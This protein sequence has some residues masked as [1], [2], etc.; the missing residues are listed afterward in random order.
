MHALSYFLPF[1]RTPARTQYKRV[2]MEAVDMK[3]Y[4]HFKVSGAASLDCL[5]NPEAFAGRG[6]EWDNAF[7]RQVRL[8]YS[9]KPKED[10]VHRLALHRRRFQD[11]AKHVIEDEARQERLLLEPYRKQGLEGKEAEAE[12]A[13]SHACDLHAQ[14]ADSVADAALKLARIEGFL[15]GEEEEVM[16]VGGGEAPAVPLGDA[17]VQTCDSSGALRPAGQGRGGHDEV[18]AVREIGG[19]HLMEACLFG[20]HEKVKLLV[21]TQMLD[22]NTLDSATGRT[23]LSLAAAY[24]CSRSVHVLLGAGAR[25][26]LR[27]ADGSILL[28][29]ACKRGHGALIF[30][31][32]QALKSAAPTV[33]QTAG[34]PAEPGPRF[35]D[36]VCMQNQYG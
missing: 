9:T 21:A 25:P 12:E 15:G 35:V 32:S 18:H 26:D 30:Y 23:P 13:S 36:L 34:A 11:A 7:V 4:C 22:V 10:F 29:S 19:E 27:D 31:I 24:G 3:R 16:A 6:T 33:P 14:S 20:V 28:H 2:L 1:A 5:V 17:A 8:L